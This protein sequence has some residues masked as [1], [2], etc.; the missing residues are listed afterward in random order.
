MK[1]LSRYPIALVSAMVMIGASSAYAA[2][3][4]AILPFD[5]NPIF[6]PVTGLT[7]G[8]DF[9]ASSP[10]QAGFLG[11]AASNNKTYNVTTNG[12]TF[13]IVVTNANAGNASRDRGAT[14]LGNAVGDL[15]RDFEQ[16]HGNAGVTEFTLTLTGLA[17]NFDYEIYFW[18]MN[19]GA[20]HNTLNFYDG[21]S[22]S[23]PLIGASTTSGNS[24]NFATWRTGAIIGKTSD[25]TGQIVL[26][27]AAPDVSSRVNINGIMVI[28][29][30]ASLILLGLGSTMMLARRRT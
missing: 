14:W 29:E 21:A 7:G 26:T 28:P 4:T 2:T 13:D 3:I 6:S 25:A 23:D 24:N 1:I 15:E 16:W 19:N 30:P 12:I 9:N 22:T 27:A 11:I 17:S 10:T 20:G 5:P 18:H 8:I